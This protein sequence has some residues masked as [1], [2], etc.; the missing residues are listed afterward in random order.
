MG[1]G[2]SH[3]PDDLDVG[4]PRRGLAIV[5]G[6]V[7]VI[8]TLLALAAMAALWPAASDVPRDRNPIEGEGVSTVSATVDAVEAFDCGS[9]GEGPDQLPTVDGDCAQVVAETTD[10]PAE[11]T[12]DSARFQAGIEVG[13]EVELIRIQPE[14]QEASYEFLDYKRSTP[15]LALGAAFAVLAIV[16]A[17]W[18]GVFALLGI[19]VALF[20]LLKFM[21][22]ALLA[23]EPPLLVAV[24]GSTLI[25]VVLLYLAH[26]VSIRTTSALFG[27]LFGIAFTALL[28]VMATGWA[29]LTGIGSE[30]DRTLIATVPDLNMAGI[31]GATMVIAGLGVLNDVTVTQASIVWEMRALRPTAKAAELFTSAMRIGRDHIASS[32]YTLVFA[33]AGASMTVLLLITAYQRDLGQMATTEEIGQEIVRSLVGMIGLILA[34]PM[35]TI[36]AVALAPPAVQDEDGTSGGSHRRPLEAGA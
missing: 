1:H 24:V 22:P 16:V 23:G 2:H 35:T 18:R 27:T 34:V 32:T 31:V 26:G 21:L 15:L 13:D 17:R 30:D 7:V 11:F 14:G 19:G 28:G 9:G 25:M 6:V 12:L 20:A 5:L 8:I 10:G 33:Y 29:S 3:A 36:V 4:P